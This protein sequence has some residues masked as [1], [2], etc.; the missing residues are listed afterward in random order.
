MVSSNKKESEGIALLSMYNEE[1]M[2]DV[3]SDED[4]EIQNDVDLIEN[5]LPPPPNTVCSEELQEKI[6]T[7]V[8]RDRS[9]REL[10]CFSKD[11]FDPHG[12]DKSDYYVEIDADV[13]RE[14]E[15]RKE[16]ERRRSQRVDF[17]VGGIQPPVV[18]PAL[19]GNMQRP[20]GSVARD[21]KYAISAATLSAAARVGYCICTTKAKRGWREKIS[22]K[23]R[24]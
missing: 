12:Y 14:V 19:D 6:N 8:S 10:F 20:A 4:S 2:E 13:R 21:T 11:V 15:R 22:G 18:A 1:E 9:Y 7:E 16:R 3:Y 5:F 23:R 17:V 24:S